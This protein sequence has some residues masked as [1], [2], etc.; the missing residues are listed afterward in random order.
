[1]DHELCEYYQ[2]VTKRLE[3]KELG[4]LNN[5]M[6]YEVADCTHPEYHQTLGR[7]PCKGDKT[8]CIL[9]RS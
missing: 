4:R 5:I 2:I 6:F 1:M 9:T 7:L 8:K 3:S